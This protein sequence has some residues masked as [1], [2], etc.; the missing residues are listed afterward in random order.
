M[1]DHLLVSIS[2]SAFRSVS[3]FLDNCALRELIPLGALDDII[4]NQHSAIVARF[5]YEDI[6]VFAFLV[7]KDIV[8]LEG[9]GLTR[10][11]V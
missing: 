4:Q 11:H 1:S 3:C 6:L 5:E 2:L 7:V 10:P 8:D 9:H